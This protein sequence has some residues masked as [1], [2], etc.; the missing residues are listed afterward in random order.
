M[1]EACMCPTMLLIENE[2]PRAFQNG[3]IHALLQHIDYCNRYG[4]KVRWHER[5]INALISKPFPPWDYLQDNRWRPYVLN[6]QETVM[7]P[8]NR[9]RLGSIDRCRLPEDPV[10][11]VIGCFAG[12]DEDISR[13][14]ICWLEAWK[15]RA[16]CPIDSKGIA[17]SECCE[18]FEHAA[19][20]KCDDI[21][22]IVEN[23]EWRLV[24]YPWLR[25]YDSR[26]PED[27]DFPFRPHSNWREL[28][29]P[30]RG[31]GNGL[32]DVEGNEWQWREHHGYHW[33]V[34]L[35]HTHGEHKRVTPDGRIL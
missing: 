4:I 24:K 2:D 19:Y 28:D 27:G 22:I 20:P 29:H 21:A 30:P 10:A 32:L 34:Q 1:C 23:D 11:V 33:D 31:D 25:F 18:R 12:E 9:G 14:W 17:A 13:I 6:W 15:A 3:K 5:L 35:I 26:L 7:G 16:D 8:L